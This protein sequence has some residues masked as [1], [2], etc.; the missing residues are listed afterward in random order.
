MI[1]RPTRF[2]LIAAAGALAVVMV[3][4]LAT[5]ELPIGEAVYMLAGLVGVVLAGL[6]DW[7]L[8]RLARKAKAGP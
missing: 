4:K 5:P 8:E 1:T 2:S 7:L 3:F 6:A